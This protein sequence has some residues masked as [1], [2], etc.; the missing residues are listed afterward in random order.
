MMHLKGFWKRWSCSNR[1]TNPGACLDGLRNFVKNG[2]SHCLDWYRTA[3]LQKV[4]LLPH[5]SVRFHQVF[6][7]YNIKSI[8]WPQLMYNTTCQFGHPVSSATW[9]N[10]L[11]FYWTGKFIWYYKWSLLDNL[12]TCLSWI[13]AIVSQLVIRLVCKLNFPFLVNL[14][15]Y[16]MCVILYIGRSSHSLAEISLFSPPNL[17]SSKLWTTDKNFIVAYDPL[18]YCRS[19]FIDRVNLLLSSWTTCQ[20]ALWTVHLL[21]W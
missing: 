5:P 13:L 10:W 4:S 7:C 15:S 3:H 21:R 12:A 9:H 17:H 16:I 11:Q 19:L 6:V 18:R 8:R 20:S 2:S 1:S 14:K